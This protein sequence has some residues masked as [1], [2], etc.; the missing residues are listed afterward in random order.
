MTAA[1]WVSLWVS[2]PPVT[3]RAG[4]VML[5]MPISSSLTPRAGLARAGRDGRTGHRRETSASSYQVTSVRPAGAPTGDLETGRRIRDQAQRPVT[6]RVRPVTT[7]PGDI[8]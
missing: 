7:P 2:T 6:P 3:I 5:V 4:S 8:L 1:T